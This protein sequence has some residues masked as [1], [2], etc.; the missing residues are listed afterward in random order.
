MSKSAIITWPILASRNDVSFLA[1]FLVFDRG[2][3]LF[4]MASVASEAGS[5]AENH[6]LWMPNHHRQGRVF[7]GKA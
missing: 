6:N 2:F 1:F 7:S 3:L 4:S 5:G